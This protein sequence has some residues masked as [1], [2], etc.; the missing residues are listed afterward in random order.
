MNALEFAVVR[1]VSQAVKALDDK[2]ISEDKEAE[3]LRTIR[4]WRPVMERLMAED[5]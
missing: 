5:R 4:F 3:Y 2:S 1:A